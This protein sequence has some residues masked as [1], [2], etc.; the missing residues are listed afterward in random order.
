[1]T[2][3]LEETVKIDDCTDCQTLSGSAFRISVPAARN[4]FSLR[5]GQPK[6]HVK[7]A[8]SGTKRAQAFCRNVP[9][10]RMALS[11][12]GT[13]QAMFGTDVPLREDIE[14]QLRDIGAL[15]LSVADLDDTYAGNA[16]RL[17]GI[18]LSSGL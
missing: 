5:G 16:A 1:V 8:E 15:G 13:K 3:R 9:T 12:F 18:S 10:L 7:T 14:L 17:L 2:E 4:S 6:I 11:M